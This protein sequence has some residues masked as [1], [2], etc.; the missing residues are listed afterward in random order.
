MSNS[1][2]DRDFYAWSL[3]QAQLLR[4]GKVS[5][6]DPYHIAEEIKSL[7]KYE[8]RELVNRLSVLLVQSRLGS[9]AQRDRI[10]IPAG[11][12]ERHARNRT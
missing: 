10:R 2:Y 8:K 6:A 9:H 7:G 12:P 11:D 3:E 4:S 5:E 1:T